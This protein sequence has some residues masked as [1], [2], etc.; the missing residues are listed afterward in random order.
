MDLS[1]SMCFLLASANENRDFGVAC[2]R[3]GTGVRGATNTSDS[4]FGGSGEGEELSSR[5]GGDSTGS[6]FFRF[7][8][9]SLD[10]LESWM[11]RLSD[12]EMHVRA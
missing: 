8:N 3:W 5:W 6:G 4:R 12:M 1:L 7:R 2:I 11:C 10:M 9:L